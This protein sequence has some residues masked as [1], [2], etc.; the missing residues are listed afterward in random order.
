LVGLLG[1]EDQSKANAHRIK[2]F[3]FQFIRVIYKHVDRF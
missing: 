3:K 1:L 2:R